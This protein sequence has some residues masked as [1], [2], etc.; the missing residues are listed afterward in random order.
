MIEWIINLSTEEKCIYAIVFP[1]I[2]GI[3]I[4]LVN[5]VLNHTL[6]SRRERRKTLVE[7]SA[8]FRSV[9]SIER[10]A[11]FREYHLFDGLERGLVP[12]HGEIFEGEYFKH[13]RAVHEYRIYLRFYDRVRLNK[14]WKKYHGGDEENPDLLQ[15]CNRDDGPKI[16]RKRLEKLRSIA[17]K[18]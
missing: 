12:G 15:Y 7:V 18:K 6:S 5:Q 1:V 13:K 17:N 16:L 9:I 10:I 4:A 3:I 2:A 8:K 11:P 14:A